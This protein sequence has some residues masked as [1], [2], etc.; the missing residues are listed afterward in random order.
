[1]SLPKATDQQIGIV[2]GVYVHLMSN[3]NGKFRAGGRSLL[4]DSAVTIISTS[5]RS[6]R[7][8]LDVISSTY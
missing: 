3:F 8:L 5:S 1:M 7:A 4:T 2:L 6:K